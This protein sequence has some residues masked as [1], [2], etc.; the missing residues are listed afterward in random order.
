MIRGSGFGDRGSGIGCQSAVPSEGAADRVLAIDPG[1]AKC[2]LALVSR[3]GQVL[4]RA[5][6][7]TEQTLDEIRRLMAAYLPCALVIGM[8]TGSKPLYEAL[9]TTL[10]E[11]PLHPVDESYTSE[12]AR[13]RYLAENPPRG[14]QR[15]LPRCLR[16][17]PCPYDDYV[18]V[19]LA[20]RYWTMS[21]I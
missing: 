4:F 19:I 15:I 14:L 1:R 17:P 16:T 2:G 7:P 5:V 10:A 9:K 20:E 13:A 8:G 21:A 18:A 6:V 12:A 3:E 11:T